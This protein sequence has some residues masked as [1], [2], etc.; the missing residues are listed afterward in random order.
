MTKAP[1]VDKSAT[2]TGKTLADWLIE[3]ENEDAQVRQRAVE[4]FYNV[5]H[6]ANRVPEDKADLDRNVA[7]QA[8]AYALKDKE[9]GV[10]SIAVMA[11]RYFGSDAS[12]VFFAVLKESQDSKVRRNAAQGLRGAPE[13][14]IPDLSELLLKD[15]NEQVRSSAA[16]ALCGIGQPGRLILL[17]GLTSGDLQ[18]RKIIVRQLSALFPPTRKEV[19]ALVVVLKDTKNT[20]EDMLA[21]IAFALGRMGNDAGEALPALLTLSKNAG[22]DGKAAL[23]ALPAISKAPRSTAPDLITLRG[24]SNHM[25]GSRPSRSCATWKKAIRNAWRLSWSW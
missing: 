15:R 3:L 4:V 10:R 22:P 6:K 12:P 18:T 11:L 7:L 13:A 19:P 16:D 20:D 5:F 24:M 2:F 25:S 23:R 8:L 14:A 17:N 1:L 21:A 9:E